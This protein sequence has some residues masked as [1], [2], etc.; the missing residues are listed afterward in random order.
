MD[1]NFADVANSYERFAESEG[2]LSPVY[3]TW[4]LA[5]GRSR[6]AC[7]LIAELPGT[8]RQP[9]LVFAAA[10]WVSQPDEATSGWPLDTAAPDE[11]LAFLRA[12]WPE[13]KTLALERS[14]Q[15]NEPGRC[16]LHLT[17]LARI[18][19]PIALIEVGHSAGLT[20]IPD[21]YSYEYT[22]TDGSRTRLSPLSAPSG[23]RIV[24]FTALEGVT[25]PTKLPTVVWRGGVDLN[26]LTLD[27]STPEGRDQ[28]RWMEALIWPGHEVRA[29]RLLRA[30]ALAAEAR[31]R[32]PF[33]EMTGDLLTGLP[34]LVKRAH[35]EAPGAHVVV[36]HTAVIAYL[37]EPAVFEE[38]MHRLLTES[39]RPGSAPLTW[40]SCEG[41]NVLPGVASA[42]SAASAPGEFILA[43]NG[44]PVART[45]PW[46]YSM[47]AL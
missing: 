12:H 31:R 21:L 19:G 41:P 23:E 45:H 6:E 5:I 33:R 40:L 26:P 3:R 39:Q 38:L 35:A 44:E 46:G 36:L 4:S 13:I 42:L 20:L 15:T 17:E 43:R 1:M 37:P 24:L 14:T 30:A 7:E 32:G 8:K 16:A 2:G 18:D 25:P 29:S 11:F 10:R 27:P 47:R 9:N 28:I 22:L 34:A